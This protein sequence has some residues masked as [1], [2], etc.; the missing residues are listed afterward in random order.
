MSSLVPRS[1]LPR[2]CSSCGWVSMNDVVMLPAPKSG[3]SSTA[4]RNGMLVETPR[5]RNSATARRAFCDRLL[6]RPAA[7]GELG[8]HRV[9]VGGDLG[10]GVRRTA[11]EADAAAAGGA[12]RRDLAGVGAEVVGRVLGGDPALQRRARAAGS[13]SCDR[14]RSASVSPEAIRSC[15][16]TRSTSVTSSVTVC[17]TWIRGFI[18]MKT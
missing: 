17:S 15:D 3:S 2:A 18:S 10:A 16:C 11:V 6:E 9:E 4:C 8:Q 14:P 13:S 7:T 5:I 12:V 1:P